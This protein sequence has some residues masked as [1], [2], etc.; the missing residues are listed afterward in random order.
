MGKRDT[1]A[2]RWYRFTGNRLPV[3]DPEDAVFT[4]AATD[5]T[6]RELPQFDPSELR[7]PDESKGK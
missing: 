7:A 1:R 4:N 6:R 3:A 2:P 5:Y